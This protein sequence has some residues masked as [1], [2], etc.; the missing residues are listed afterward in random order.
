MNM[1][2]I[3]ITSLKQRQITGKSTEAMSNATCTNVQVCYALMY[4]MHGSPPNCSTQC[5]ILRSASSIEPGGCQP[6]PHS[7]ATAGRGGGEVCVS[8]VFVYHAS[9]Q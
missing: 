9:G 3:D 5:P 1:Q 4:L 6:H 2:N 8:V 7:T